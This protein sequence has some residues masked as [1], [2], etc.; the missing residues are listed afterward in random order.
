MELKIVL[1]SGTAV[2]SRSVESVTLP[3]K[4]GRFT[5]LKSHAPLVS[6]LETGSIVYK[7]AEGQ[8]EVA[9]YSGFCRVENNRIEIAAE[10]AR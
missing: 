8:H 3:G 7:D 5:V 9:I 1:P 2:D 4:A 6:A 10:S